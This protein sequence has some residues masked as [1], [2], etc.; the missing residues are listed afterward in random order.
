LSYLFE[1][2]DGDR[3]HHV[4]YVETWDGIAHIYNENETIPP[5]SR[6]HYDRT[7]YTSCYDKD[8]SPNCRTVFSEESRALVGF[9]GVTT[10]I[11]EP[12]G[13]GGWTALSRSQKTFD[14]GEGPIP[15]WLNGKTLTAATFDPA[16][17]RQ[18]TGQTFNWGWDNPNL[19]AYLNW[20]S[21]IN[22]DPNGGSQTIGTCEAYA[23]STDYQ[24]GKQWGQRTNTK[25]YQSQNTT[26]PCGGSG[27]QEYR[28]MITTYATNDDNPHLIVPSASGL[29]DPGYNNAL[30]LT[31]N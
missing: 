21:N 3:W 7:G 12:D 20:T 16:N 14:I 18:L 5:Q 1:M 24:G 30:Q 26:T 4:N 13:L 8:E 15:Y 2:S 6:I 29:Y 28:N 25:Y 11:E 17:N 22:Y 19:F 31:L 23:Y 10:T 9:S 27:W